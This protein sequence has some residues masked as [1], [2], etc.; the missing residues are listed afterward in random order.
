MDSVSPMSHFH[1]PHRIPAQFRRDLAADLVPLLILERPGSLHRVESD[2][3]DLPG[4]RHA[5]AVR[6]VVHRN[7]APSVHSTWHPMHPHQLPD[8]PEIPARLFLVRVVGPSR[9]LQARISLQA[10]SATHSRITLA[11]H[12]VHDLQPLLQL[13]ARSAGPGLAPLLP[14]PLHPFDHPVVLGG[15]GRIGLHPDVQS[16][17]PADQIGGQVA[18]RSPG[19][20]VVDSQPLGPAPPLERESQGLLGFSGIDLGP[21]PEGGKR[22]S[23]RRPRS[24][25]PQSEASR[26]RTCPP[27]GCTPRRRPASSGADA[28]LERRRT[29]NQGAGRPAP[30]RGRRFGTIVGSSEGWARRP[31]AAP[32]RASRGSIRPPKSGDGDARRGSPGEPRRD[33]HDR[34]SRVRDS[35]EEDRHPPAREPV[36]GDDARCEAR[37]RRIEPARRRILPEPLAPRFSGVREW[38]QAWAS[39]PPPGKS[40]EDQGCS[41]ISTHDSSCGKTLVSD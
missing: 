32:R 5:H 38:G 16:G 15:S 14:D 11:L 17:Q 35:W 22:R 2:P 9:V 24:P 34:V 26:L 19:R 8:L 25:R 13:D 30:E 41:P 1:P 36:S 10:G 27:A 40:R 4:P 3:D 33:R 39:R 6:P 37:G 7:L 21:A 18:P 28:R 20:A 29:T 23:A 12:P 31:E